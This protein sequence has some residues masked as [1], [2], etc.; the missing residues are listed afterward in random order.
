MHKN[1]RSRDMVTR[2]SLVH[3]PANTAPPLGRTCHVTGIPR[4]HWGAAA[5]QEAPFNYPG[6]IVHVRVVKATNMHVCTAVL[7]EINYRQLDYRLL[8]RSFCGGVCGGVGS[9]IGLIGGPRIEYTVIVK[10]VG[11]LKVAVFMFQLPT[12]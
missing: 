1:K 12:V 3:R 9:L 10:G 7:V 11:R 2:R 5:A 8:W 6:D 4:R